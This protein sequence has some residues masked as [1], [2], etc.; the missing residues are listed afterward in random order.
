MR[1][2]DPGQSIVRREGKAAQVA[3]KNGKGGTE[4]GYT[5]G[6]WLREEKKERAHEKGEWV[7]YPVS[8]HSHTHTPLFFLLTQHGKDEILSCVNLQCSL[9]VIFPLVVLRKCFFFLIQ[10]N[11][12]LFYKRAFRNKIYLITHLFIQQPS[13]KFLLTVR[14][15]SL[16][17]VHSSK[18]KRPGLCSQGAYG[19]VRTANVRQMN[20]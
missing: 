20:T 17:K 5:P 3:A 1:E 14:Q 8:H 19:Q 10:T 2:R 11:Q 6:T 18:L 12:E 9:V 16:H 13:I 15:Y 4:M 7:L